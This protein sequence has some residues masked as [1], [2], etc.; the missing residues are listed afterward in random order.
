MRSRWTER[1]K[2]KRKSNE[3]E[4][5][6]AVKARAS[7]WKWSELSRF[8]ISLSITFTF[9]F[10]NFRHSSLI[11]YSSFFV[12][13]HAVFR[14]SSTPHCRWQ[15]SRRWWS[16]VWFSTKFFFFCACPSAVSVSSRL[17]LFDSSI[18]S[19]TEFP[20]VFSDF[21]FL[22]SSSLSRFAFSDEFFLHSRSD[23]RLEFFFFDFSRIETSRSRCVSMAHRLDGINCHFYL[24]S[25]ANI[26]KFINH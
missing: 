12:L 8:L 24:H 22:A 16:R 2:E 3:R 19:F 7:E 18:E 26:S 4:Q 9:P 21:S 15:W 25:S 14:N 23:F 17:R 11:F 1:T 20:P 10:S 6:R 5:R 13:S